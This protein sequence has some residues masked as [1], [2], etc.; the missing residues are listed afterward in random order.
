[1]AKN[2]TEHLTGGEQRHQ[3]N[4]APTDIQSGSPLRR[5][6][7]GGKT[8]IMTSTE[9]QNGFGR[10]LDAVANEGTVLIKKHNV[11]RAVVISANR[12]AALTRE[13]PSTLDT[14]TAEFDDLLARLQTPESRAGLQDAF[15]A[16]SSELGNAAVAAAQRRS[17]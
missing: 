8:L 6:P 2:S 7:S 10:M 15:G 13:E 14:L 17:E 12:Y 16:S 5:F 11:T 3:A 9:A 1:M 4:E